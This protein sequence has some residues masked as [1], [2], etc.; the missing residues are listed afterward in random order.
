MACRN[1][2]LRRGDKTG[3][4]AE[5]TPISAEPRGRAEWT[6]R[7][8]SETTSS[9]SSGVRP[10]RSESIAI[11]PGERRQAGGDGEEIARAWLEAAGWEI[12]DQNVS[13]RCGELDLVARDRDQIV[14]VEVRSRWTHRGGTGAHSV[15]RTKQQRL[16]RAAHLYLQRRGWTRVSARFDAISVDL[17]AGRVVEHFRGAFDACER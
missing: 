10:E 12:L 14:F 5:W 13:F 3:R 11:A 16:T 17:Q 2:E 9:A 15:G 8:A 6:P 1:G 4:R 7:V